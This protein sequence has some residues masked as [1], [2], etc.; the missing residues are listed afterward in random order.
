MSDNLSAETRDHS[1][2]GQG[3]APPLGKLFPK[4]IE[5]H[6]SLPYVQRWLV[7]NRPHLGSDFAGCL[8]LCM[9]IFEGFAPPGKDARPR[10]R[11]RLWR[12][13]CAYWVA[14]QPSRGRSQNTRGRLPEPSAERLRYRCGGKAN[15]ALSQLPFLCMSDS[16]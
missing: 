14:G 12:T 11:P 9:N 5:L 4:C 1:S 16:V 2:G 15:T 7:R 8:L 10:R 13:R 3:R 6:C